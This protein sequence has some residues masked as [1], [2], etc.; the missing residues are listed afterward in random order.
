MDSCFDLVG[1]RQHSVA[2]CEV[3]ISWSSDILKPTKCRWWLPQMCLSTVSLSRQRHDIVDF[4]YRPLSH[5][6]HVHWPMGMQD[7]DLSFI[8]GH[9]HLHFAG[10]LITSK[11]ATP[12]GRDP[13]R[14]KQLSTVPILG[15]Q[16]GLYHAVAP[17]SFLRSISLALLF[18]IL[19]IFGWPDLFRSYVNRQH[20]RLRPFASLCFSNNL[21]IFFLVGT[22]LMP[23][24]NV[25]FFQG[26]T[27]VYPVT[28]LL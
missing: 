22:F 9:H 10:R 7:L 19:S 1:S 17:L 2:S 5:V 4:S 20:F 14:S 11:L 16:F 26:R 23:C 18:A 21:V 6:L 15:F 8:W 13:T 12:W 3:V 25:S 28:L 24:E 27:T